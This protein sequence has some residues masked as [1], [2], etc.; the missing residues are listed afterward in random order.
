MRLVNTET[1]QLG[2]FSGLESAPPFAILSHTWGEQ[3]CSFSDMQDPKVA[4]RAGYAK[5]E[6]CCEQARKDG[7]QWAW[8]D[9]CV[10]RCSQSYACLTNEA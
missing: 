4:L 9:T 2:D 5:I 6:H 1:L 3:E 7:L 10:S 8:I